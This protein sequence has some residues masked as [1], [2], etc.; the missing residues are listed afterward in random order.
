MPGRRGNYACEREKTLE[1]TETAHWGTVAAE[2]ACRSSG[3]GLGTSSCECADRKGPRMKR[4][5]P[6]P[7]SFKLLTLNELAELPPAQ[8]LIEPLFQANSQIVLYGP[9][10]VGKSFVALSF[11]LSIASGRDWLGHRVTQG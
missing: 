10:G 8:W 6:E 4:T 3:L 11:A 5:Q 7:K 1:K 2:A 9:P